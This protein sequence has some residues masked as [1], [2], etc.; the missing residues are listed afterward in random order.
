MVKIFRTNIRHR[1]TAKK[2]KD[3]LLRAYPDHRINFDLEDCDQIL[4]L[5]GQMS[6]SE[7][8][9]QHLQKLGHLCEELE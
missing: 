4:R 5:E 8:I 7:E 6:S 9:I 1:S 3:S 2:V